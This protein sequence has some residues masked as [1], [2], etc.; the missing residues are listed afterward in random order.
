M[1]LENILEEL[2]CKNAF[3]KNG[4]LSSSGR[5]KYNKLIKLLKQC[6]LLVESNNVSEIIDKLDK[7]LSEN[8]RT[9]KNAKE[10]N[11]FSEKMAKLESQFGYENFVIETTFYET[12][13]YKKIYFKHNEKC[14]YIGDSY[15]TYKILKNRVIRLITY[16]EEI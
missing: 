14:V 3:N 5:K 7:I 9:Y 4:C 10:L 15:S 11:K 8:V 2:G 13:N 6:S 16:K 12:H 1:T